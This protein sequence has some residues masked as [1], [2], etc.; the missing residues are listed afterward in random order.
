MVYLHTSFYHRVSSFSF[1]V[2]F[3]DFLLSIFNRSLCYQFM[4]HSK[5]FE[6]SVSVVHMK[7]LKFFTKSLVFNFL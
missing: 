3:S 5:W 2:H 1:L 7:M 4:Y 6:P